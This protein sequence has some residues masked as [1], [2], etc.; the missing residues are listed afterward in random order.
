MFKAGTEPALRAVGGPARLMLL[1]G[2]PLGRRFMWW[3]FVSSRQE[4]IEQAKADWLAGRMSLPVEETE[5]I[6]L[7]TV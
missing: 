1:G 4:R 5:F 3:N 6:P 7:P 2:E